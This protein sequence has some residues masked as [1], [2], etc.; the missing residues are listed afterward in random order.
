M[1]QAVV[2]PQFSH[3]LGS[4]VHYP[5]GMAARNQLVCTMGHV[6]AA[7][8]GQKGRTF[9][10]FLKG[11]FAWV[12]DCS[13]GEDCDNQSEDLWAEHDRPKYEWLLGCASIKKTT[14]VDA[15]CAEE[16]LNLK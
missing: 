4:A 12:G 1:I 13:G 7:K 10:C 11:I 2:T 5:I 16:F 9:L 8:R 6:G 15:Q 3:L 14:L